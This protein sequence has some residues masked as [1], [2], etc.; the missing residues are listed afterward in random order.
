MSHLQKAKRQWSFPIGAWLC[1]AVTCL[2]LNAHACAQ[3]AKEP[4]RKPI[5]L[6]PPFENQAKQH[7]F[8][9]YEVG[10]SNDPNRPKKNYRV[11]RYTE[12]PR[13][14]F[15][16]LLN[17]IEGVT[18]IERQRVDTLLAES[19]F[20]QFSGLVDPDKALK[21]GK[22][23]GANLIIVGS[24]VDLR[25]ET[26]SFKGYGIATENVTVNCQIRFRLLD[27][28][29]KVLFSKVVKGS[30]QYSKSTFG[31]TK[32]SDRNFAAIEV[33][34][35]KIGEDAQFKAAILGKKAA[36]PGSAGAGAMIEVEFAPQPDNCDIE[37]DGKYIG[38]SPLKRKMV[39]GKEYKIH[40]SKGGYKDW[41]G[42]ITPEDGLR[43]T[44]TLEPNRK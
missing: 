6:V 8:I 25:D 42:V 32:S 19:E 20:G 21:L 29:G 44:R 40:I 41:T 33:A 5:I 31:G 18:I 23:L 27:E 15:E 12:A 26:N 3:E 10:N 37:I 30:K 17:N 36:S 34:I 39:S 11:D 22:L 38:G 4:A 24:I 7:E 13:S 1:V 28:T 2:G 14:L 16:N 9:N 35:D 43:I